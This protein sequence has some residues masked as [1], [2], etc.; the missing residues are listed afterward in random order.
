ML[1]LLPKCTKSSDKIVLLDVFNEGKIDMFLW[2]HLMPS[3]PT[4][5]H[6][7]SLLLLEFNSTVALFVNLHYF[8]V[9]N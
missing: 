2:L 7:Y 6:P 9:M 5:T 3:C 1:C 8:S 4:P